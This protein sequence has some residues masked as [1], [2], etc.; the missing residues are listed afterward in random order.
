MAQNDFY[1]GEEVINYQQKCPVVFV[2]DVS[3]SMSGTPINELNKGLKA[4]EQEI[5]EDLTAS[6]RLDV[7]IV[8]FGSD[9][10]IEH[11]FALMGEYQMPNLGITGS[12]NLEAGMRKGME[13]LEARKKWYR[14]S[15][16][17]YY[18]PYVILVTDGAPDKDPNSTGLTSDIKSAVK[19]KKFNFWPIGVE[20]ANMELLNQMACPGE[21]ASLPAMKLDGLKFVELFQW[22]SASFG[23]VSNSKDGEGIDVTPEE[24]K[25][26]F[27][28]TV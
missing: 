18:R 23:K 25:N 5:Q 28:I 17:T 7:A 6:S 26:P 12:T 14:E 10:K 16:Q 1:N 15:K 2:L 8:S 13:I 11:D 19:S 21:G 9:A 24:G 20:G 22:L 4:F 3:G 27:M